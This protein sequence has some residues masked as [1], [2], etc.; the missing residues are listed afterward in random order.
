MFKALNRKWVVLVILLSAA[1][2]VYSMD[3]V[4]LLKSQSDLDN[5]DTHKNEVLTRALE[6]TEPE[7]GSFSITIDGP[8]MSRK[9]ALAAMQTG[10]LVNVF[11]SPASSA[12]DEVAIAIKVPIRR[13]LLSY[14]LLLV[15]K[16]D[17]PKFKKVKTAEDLRRFSVGLQTGW[18]AV[19]IFNQVGFQTVVTPSYDGLFKMLDIHRFSFIPRGINDVFDEIDSHKVLTPNV[20]I[21]PTLALYIVQPT[22]VYVSQ[23]EPR[24]AQRISKGLDLMVKSGEL[25]KIFYKNFGAALE[26]AK[27]NQRRLI[28]IDNPIFEDK[29]LLENKQLWY[30]MSE[31]RE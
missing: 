26:R 5:R 31:S 9:R 27:L 23:T 20:V 22:Y 30:E 17:L 3:R 12:W 15:H 25:K 14:R 4:R 24:L 16:A 21:E 19:E 2:S 6:L 28:K 8:R 10:E 11:M 13:G 18:E 29:A 1:Q 7:Y